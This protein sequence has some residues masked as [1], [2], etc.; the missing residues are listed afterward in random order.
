M[1]NMSST[2][3]EAP[4]VVVDKPGR[5]SKHEKSKKRHRETTDL[6]DGTERKHKRSKSHASPEASL[7]TSATGSTAPAATT[8]NWDGN[9]KKEKRTRKSKKTQ[10]PAD[11]AQDTAH[12]A[13]DAETARV[14]SDD[15]SKEKKRSKK[16]KKRQLAPDVD[17]PQHNSAPALKDRKKEKK[18][19]K[20]DP[21]P[22][23]TDSTPSRPATKVQENSAAY[24][25][26]FF[27]QTVS[28]YLPLFPQ[29]MTEPIEGYAEQH[30]RPLLNRYVSTFRGV[31]LAYR[32]P[33]IGEAPGKGSLSEASN[34]EATA[35]LECIDEYAVGFS[36]LT[37][38]ADLFCP[39]RGSWMEGSLN[40]QSE[41]FIGVICYEM[42]NAS[43]EASRLP[44]GWKWVDLMTGS[45]D[46]KG[47][48]QK[49][50]SAA[51]A[52]LPTPEPQ[53]E[54]E[55]EGGNA[56]GNADEKAPAD[57]DYNEDDSTGQAHSTGYWVDQDGSK[58]SGKLR[59]RIKNY[60]VGFIGDYGYLSIEG[61]MLDEKAER[62]RVAE[63]KETDRRRKLKQGGWLRKSLK[64]LPEFS[65]TKF[66]DD[67]QD[68]ILPSMKPKKSGG[69]ETGVAEVAEAVE[70]V[71]VMG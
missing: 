50:Q 57:E 8:V 21:E 65:M 32:N 43:I 69:S 66:G 41:G 15:S 30:L 62:V 34:I 61:T 10:L 60:E 55:D 31:L 3:V 28:Q 19:R 17:F 63:E 12:T 37:V 70:T 25:S 7:V 42:F 48:R 53:T 33:R 5:K 1:D 35:L 59:F 29:G 54:N 71:E 4:P 49:S 13:G 67:E 27:T 68:D 6:V 26:P 51:E 36:W 44:S 52:K 64:R 16:E 56:D 46:K 2:A 47:E 24:P 20:D 22:M 45:R 9:S 11:E 40:L 38:D 23:I 58:V 14:D 39:R 18:R